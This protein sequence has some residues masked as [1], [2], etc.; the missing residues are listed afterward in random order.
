MNNSLNLSMHYG[1][2][3]VSCGL[4]AYSASWILLFKKISATHKTQIG[5]KDDPDMHSRDYRL[6]GYRCEINLNAI[7]IT[8]VAKI[9]TTLVFSPAK[10]GFKSVFSIFCCSVSEI[11]VYI[12]KHSFCH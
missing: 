11:S 3:T 6:P 8:V 1:S 5:V 10:N 4:W 12:S 9:I 7:M 2:E